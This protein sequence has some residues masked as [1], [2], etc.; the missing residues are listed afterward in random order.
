[1]LIKAGGLPVSAAVGELARSEMSAVQGWV[2]TIS[3]IPSLLSTPVSSGW[4]VARIVLQDAFWQ[5]MQSFTKVEEFP[6]VLDQLDLTIAEVLSQK[7][8]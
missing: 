7:T 4:G 8:P 6:V 5:A 1:M 3:W 2:E